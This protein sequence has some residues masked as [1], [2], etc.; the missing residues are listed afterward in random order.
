MRAERRMSST[1]QNISIFQQLTSPSNKN[2]PHA[3]LRTFALLKV[4]N[5]KKPS[6]PA[7]YSRLD[8]INFRS[9]LKI[10][11]TIQISLR[12]SFYGQ[13]YWVQNCIYDRNFSRGNTIPV[14]LPYQPFHR[15]VACSVRW[16]K[17][18]P[19]GIKHATESPVCILYTPFF[20]SQAP[21]VRI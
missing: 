14:P 8:Y 5:H 3:Q 1:I 15:R 6:G 16:V 11:S 9:G 4:V 10:E 13:V 2:H 19:Y 7:E 18:R 17:I 12:E 20:D 21:V